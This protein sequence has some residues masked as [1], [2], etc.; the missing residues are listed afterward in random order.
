MYTLKNYKDLLNL[1]L[2]AENEKAP[3]PENPE[4]QGTQPPEGP[5]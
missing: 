5:V 4:A 2:K 1:C 3:V